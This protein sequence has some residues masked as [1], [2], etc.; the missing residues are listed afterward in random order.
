MNY[1]TILRRGVEV[2]GQKSPLILSGA[3][4]VGVVSTALLASKAS[5]ESD[6]I[7]KEKTKLG[8]LADADY[9]MDVKTKIKHTWRV[10]IPVAISGVTT[11]CSIVLA[12]RINS[13]RQLALAGAYALSEKALNEYRNKVT[14]MFG[15]KKE[16]Q[17]SESIVEDR[18]RNSTAAP[19]VILNENKCLCYDTLT[20]RYFESSRND[21]DHAVNAMNALILGGEGYTTLNQFY[22]Y[23]G[24]PSAQLG[25][26]IGW[27]E[28]YRIDVRY[29]S[30]LSSDGRPALAINHH[31]LPK[32]ARL[33]L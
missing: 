14:E 2:I 10:Y 16:E 27:D 32:P 33:L 19:T 6:A 28:N 11:V 18:I 8:K 24:I 31:N 9:E 12:Q 21:I 5:K 20:D 30:H 7:V 4:I 29:S 15:E 25:E 1:T 23:L 3:A 13:R 17:V 22:D 26:D